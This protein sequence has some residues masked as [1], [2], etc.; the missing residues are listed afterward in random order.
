M[1]AVATPTEA[2]TP[3]SPEEVKLIGELSRTNE[4]PNELIPD[5][6]DPQT[7]SRYLSAVS[8]AYCKAQDI[9]TRLKPF[10]GRILLLYKRRPQ[11]YLDLGYKDYDDWMSRG[12]PIL[13]GVSRGEAYNCVTIA[14]ELG[15]LTATKMEELKIGK[16]NY[17]AKAIRRTVT[18]D[19]PIEMREAKRAEWVALAEQNTVRGFKELMEAQHLIEPGE[20]EPKVVVALHVAPPVK[21]RWE[22]FVADEGIQQHCETQDGGQIFERMIDECETEWKAQVAQRFK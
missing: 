8:K 2:L 20:C 21:E 3:Y 9:M 17:L 1:E 12:V 18:E 6:I 22:G 11:L 19:M 7:L 13:H 5:D 14:E 15:F 4:S 16:L 10:F